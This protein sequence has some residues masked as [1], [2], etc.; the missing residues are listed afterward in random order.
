MSPVAARVFVALDEWLGWALVAVL[1]LLH[2]PAWRVAL[3]VHLLITYGF[4]YPLYWRAHDPWWRRRR[5]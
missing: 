3:P 4:A 2:D 1:Y 5:S